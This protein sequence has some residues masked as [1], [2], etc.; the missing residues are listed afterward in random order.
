MAG[1]FFSDDIRRTLDSA[2]LSGA[3][4]ARMQGGGS[5]LAW[6]LAG[7][8]LALCVVAAALGVAEFQE[9]A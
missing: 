5:Q 8:Y 4:W 7:Y 3:A 6:V 9:R 2:A 1:P